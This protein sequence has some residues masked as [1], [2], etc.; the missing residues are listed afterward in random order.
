MAHRLK[1]LDTI[2]SDEWTETAE[3]HMLGAGGKTWASQE[4]RRSGKP[5]FKEV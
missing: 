3:P 4:A 1:D 2:T 5:N